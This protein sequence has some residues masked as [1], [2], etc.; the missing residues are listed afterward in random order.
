MLLDN[1]RFLIFIFVAVPV[2]PTI[3][4]SLRHGFGI[5][6]FELIVIA[7]TL[8]SS[9]VVFIIMDRWLERWVER[10]SVHKEVPHFGRPIKY[11]YDRTGRKHQP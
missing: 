11:I 10:M 7:G 8:M 4:L 5:D 9:I 1:P 3:I 6:L 2:I